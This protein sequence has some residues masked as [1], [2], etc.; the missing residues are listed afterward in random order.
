MTEPEGVLVVGSIA[1][2]FVESPR[3]RLEGELGGSA[4]YFA[5]AARYFGPVAVIGAVG[6]D[7]ASELRQV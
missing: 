2:D 7:R 3:V 5:L 4:V 1:Q 6:A